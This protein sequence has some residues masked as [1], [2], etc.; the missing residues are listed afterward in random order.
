LRPSPCGPG[1]GMV[2]CPCGRASLVFPLRISAR[3]ALGLLASLESVPVATAEVQGHTTRLTREAGACSVRLRACGLDGLASGNY[4]VAL[5]ASTDGS[6]W[7]PGLAN[8]VVGD[9]TALLEIVVLARPDAR[10]AEVMYLPD[11]TLETML[12]E[13][14]AASVRVLEP[15]LLTQLSD[16]P[17]QWLRDRLLKLADIV[18]ERFEAL[19]PRFGSAQELEPMLRCAGLRLL[20]G[21]APTCAHADQ[22]ARVDEQELGYWHEEMD[23]GHRCAG[24]M[25]DGR[26]LDVPDDIL[27]SML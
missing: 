20:D 12:P 8:V 18:E 3:A 13:G 19:G 4:V 7:L 22:G 2:D 23:L 27:S 5:S 21:P 14:S 16:C 11:Q 6:G 24:S 26:R 25:D 1:L 15:M 10:R 9:S 17:G